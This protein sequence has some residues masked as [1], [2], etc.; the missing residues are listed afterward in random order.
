MVDFLEEK[1]TERVPS[2]YARATTPLSRVFWLIGDTAIDHADNSIKCHTLPGSKSLY[3]ISSFS[4]TD[5][6]LLRTREL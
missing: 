3:S 1:Y 2:S 6:T 4:I 5:P